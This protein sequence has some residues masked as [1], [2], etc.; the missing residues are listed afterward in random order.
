MDAAKAVVELFDTRDK[1]EARRLAVHLDTRNE[2]RKVVQQQIVDLAA[3]ELAD[4]SK[5]SS[6]VAVIAGEGWHR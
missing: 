6:H 1:Q 4:S 5:P 3:A 2:E